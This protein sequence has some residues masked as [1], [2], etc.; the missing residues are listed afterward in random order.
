[1]T[2]I[3]HTELAAESAAIMTGALN[4]AKRMALVKF[5]SDGD[6]VAFF[7]EV[8]EIAV[9]LHLLGH[10]VFDALDKHNESVGMVWMYDIVEATGEHIASICN[11]NKEAYSRA[12][13]LEYAAMLI[14]NAIL[15]ETPSDALMVDIAAAIKAV[16]PEFTVPE[17][18]AATY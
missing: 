2:A 1:M 12:A 8:G 5:V 3:N 4:F 16:I 13:A 15:I 9:R 11:A 18:S 17:P 7:H 14:W 6:G 10:G